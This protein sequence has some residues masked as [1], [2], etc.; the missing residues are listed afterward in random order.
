MIGPFREDE[1]VFITQKEH[2]IAFYLKRCQGNKWVNLKSKIK[3]SEIQTWTK[4][5]KQYP[6]WQGRDA[7]LFD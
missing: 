7:L 5:K 4:E 1:A 6:G 3:V 2:H